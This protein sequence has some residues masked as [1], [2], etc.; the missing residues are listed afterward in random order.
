MFPVLINPRGR[1][2]SGGL[3]PEGPTFKRLSTSGRT[4]LVEPFDVEGVDA[5]FCRPAGI[6]NPTTV[7]VG[8]R[9]FE[10]DPL[11]SPDCSSDAQD[12]LGGGTDGFAAG[13]CK[14]G[15]LATASPADEVEVCDSVDE[16]P[17][18]LAMLDPSSGSTLGTGSS[19]LGC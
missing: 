2:F 8:R 6:E 18:A 16:R 7:E 17:G 1:I 10:E 13:A 15:A 5:P 14:S 3:G 12:F 9:D 4:E 19:T 11:A